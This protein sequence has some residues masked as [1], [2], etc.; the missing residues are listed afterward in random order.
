MPRVPHQAGRSR[1]DAA[2]ALLRRCGLDPLA[3]AFLDP[4]RGA[5]P[6]P[7]RDVQF[8]LEGFHQHGLSL[9]THSSVTPRAGRRIGAGWRPVRSLARHLQ[10]LQQA[11]A[12][13][14]ATQRRGDAAS[15]AAVALLDDFPLV[16]AQFGEVR[17]GLPA[18][19]GRQLPRLADGPQA[20]L[21][22]VH[23][24]ARAFVAHTDSSFDPQLLA[25]F[26]RAYQSVQPLTLRELRTLPTALRAVLLE[27][28]AHL[29]EHVTTA[30]AARDL[31]HAC[32]DH[33]DDLAEAELEALLPR[34]RARGALTPFLA[35]MGQRLHNPAQPTPS[36]WLAWL[37]AHAP[38]AGAELAAA[39]S[40]AAANDVSVTHALQALRA[41]A[42]FDWPRF[43]EEA[44]PLLQVLRRSKAF[45]ADSALTQDQCTQQIERWA[46]RLKGDELA[47][48]ERA[49]AL[50]QAPDAPPP[51][52]VA[53]P[54]Y[55]LIGPGRAE[56]AQ[57][58]GH[59]E[60]AW[61]MPLR[62]R[63][64]LYFGTAVLG[65]LLLVQALL[66]DHNLAPWAELLSLV[67]LA[68]P[69][70]ECAFALL[71]RLI[72]EA[73]PPSRLPRLALERGL[74]PQH[75]TLVVVPC[76]LSS[77]RE[78]VTLAAQLEQ[79][80]LANP[81]RETQFALLSDWA[82]APHTQ[83][84]GD[85]LLLD[86]ARDAIASLNDRHPGP[87]G[88]A[89]R[90]LLL[91]RPRVW[92]KSEGA[93]LGWERTRGK[94]EQLL[95]YLAGRSAFPFVDLGE[96]SRLAR[97]IVY[98]L[99]LDPG[100]VVPP[101]ALRELIAIAAHPLNAPA[102]DAASGRVTAGHAV[103]Q[104]RVV[105][106][107][108]DGGGRP[109][110]V[111]RWLVGAGEWGTELP[112]GHRTEVYQDVFGEGSYA[113]TGLLDVRAAQA[114]LAGRVPESALLSHALYEGL[115]TRCAQVDDVPVLQPQ[116]MQPD[117]AA[118]RRHR[119]TRGAWQLLPFLWPALHG[120]V[121]AANL[122]KMVDPLR[123]S[124]LAPVCVL[125]LCWACATGAVPPAAAVALVLGALGLAPLSGALAA[126]VPRRR[127][128]AWRHFLRDAAT[129]LRRAALLTL[130]QFATLLDTAVREIDAIARTLWR[131]YGSR[132]R[133]LDW[134]TPEQPPTAVDPELPALARQHRL[135]LGVAFVGVLLALL[136][137]GHSTAW[138]L[139]LGALWLATPAWTWLA[140]QPVQRRSNRL[141]TEQ[142]RSL[143]HLARDTWSIFERLITEQDHHL[144]PEHLQCGPEPTVAHR[145]SPTHIGLYLLASCCAHRFGFIGTDE[146]IDRLDATL[147]S[148][149]R[150]PKHRGH[151]FHRID[152]VSLSPLAPRC[153]STADSGH[154]AA[155]L[156]AAAAACRCL[157]EGPQPQE[158]MAEALVRAVDRLKHASG[159]SLPAVLGLPA[160]KA[161]LEEDLWTLWR[162]APARLRALQQ[163]A[164]RAWLDAPPEDRESPACEPVGALLRQLQSLLRDREVDRDRWPATLRALAE[165]ADAL[166]DAMD[167]RF[168]YD[169]RR[170]LLHTGYDVDRQALSANHHTLLA[171]EARLASFVAIAKGE[172]P[173]SHW[174]ELGRPFIG[175]DDMPT[176]RSGSGSMLEY[177]MPRLVMHE[178]AG[179]LLDRVAQG[180][181]WA[182]RR[183]GAC[184]G[185]PW[186]LS[187]AA[188]FA[189][190]HT[191][192]FQHAVFGVP[193]LAARR[194]PPDEEVIAPHASVL[195]AQVDP[196]AAS[197][198]LQRL[199]REGARDR[200]GFLDA[201]DFTPSRLAEDGR[202]RRV[203]TFMTHHQAM[204][205]VALANVLHD[206][207]A[208]RWFAQSV[209]VR[210]H[211]SLLQE[212][213][214]RELVFQPSADLARTVRP[215][216]DAPVPLRQLDL[217]LRRGVPPTHLLGNGRY[218]VALRP[219]GAG[220]S[221]W[222]GRAIHRTEDDALRDA[223]GTWLLLRREGDT[224]FHSLT[225][226][227]SPHPEAR[228]RTR[229]LP[230]RVE[231]D[232]TTPSW[233]STTTVWVS[234]DDDIEFRSVE[235]HNAS[236]EAVEFE[237]LSCFE[238]V[239]APAAEHEAH[240]AGSKL[241]VR[242]HPADEGCLVLER[243]PRHPEEAAMWAAHFVAL[244]DDEPH[245]VRLIA[246]RS[247][248]VPRLGAAGEFRPGRT[249]LPRTD[250]EIPTGLDP[251][252]AIALRLTLPP[253]ARRH[254]TFATT[255]ADDL[256]TIAATV[257][258]Y[259]HEVHL[260]RSRLMAATL[261]RLRQRE[262][263]LGGQDLA[264]LQD[265]T[266]LMQLHHGRHRP[267]A[268]APLDRR[269]LW[270]FG[271]SGDKPLLLLRISGA[272]AL[273]TM[274]LLLAA[275]RLWQLA[276]LETDLVLLHQE[277][278]S[279]H[280]PLAYQVQAARAA[281]G[282][283]A[284]TGG[285]H[286]LR[287]NEVA[288]IELATLQAL[289]RVELLAD[290]QPIVRLLEPWLRAARHETT[291]PVVAVDTSASHRPAPIAQGPAPNE[292]ASGRF[293]ADGR[294][295]EILI[296]G[297][298]ITPRPWAN[299]LANPHFGCVITEAGGGFTWA[300]DSRLN[301]LTPRRCDP[302]LDPPGEQFL[303]C[304][305]DGR[306][307]FPLMPTLDRRGGE[308]WCVT[309][310]PGFTHFEQQRDSLGIETT[311]AVHPELAAKV[312]RVRL[313]NH[314]TQPRRLRLLGLVEWALGP[315]R[316]DR[317]TLLTEAATVDGLVMAQQRER[318]HGFGGGTAWLM[319][320]GAAVEQWSCAREEFF[321]GLGR[322]QWPELLSGRCGSGLDPC[323]AIASRVEIGAAASVEFTWLL[324]WAES[325]DAALGLARQLRQTAV[326]E[327]PE[328]AATRWAR[329][330]EAV[331][332]HTP[333][334]WFDALVNHWL[335]YQTLAC[336]L[337]SRAGFYE[338]HG[339]V[340]FREQLQQAM[341]LVYHDAAALRAQIVLH[342]GRQ[343]MEGDVQHHWHPASGAGPRTRVSD[344]ALWLPY[345]LQHYLEVTGD[346]SVLDEPVAFIDSPPVPPGEVHL[347]DVPTPSTD[348]AS[349]YEHAAR[350]LDHALRLGAHDLPLMGSGDV[351][352]GLDRVGHE[353][354]GE[355]VW[356][357]WLLLVLL[358]QWVPLAQRRGD[359]ERADRWPSLRQRLE[360]A[361]AQ[362]GWDG[363]WW[364]RAY[365]DSGEPLGSHQ[366]DACEIDLLPQAWSVFGSPVGD[367]RARQAMAAADARLVDR[368]AGLLRLLDPP[369]QR[370]AE[371]TG[372]I[373]AY[374]AGVRENGGQ[375]AQ[376]GV[377]ALMA[378]A[379]LGRPD[380][381]WE[382]FTLLSPAHRC[383]TPAGLRRYRLEPY[384]AAGD[385]CSQAPYEGQ[386]GRSWTTSAS[387]WLYRAAIETL[388]GLVLRGG[389]VCFAP[390]L[391]PH[392]PEARISL[393]LR[394]KRIHVLLK[395][396]Q[397]DRAE[398]PL[399]GARVVAAGQ[400]LDLS[401]LQ[402]E[403]HLLLRVPR[404]PRQSEPYAPAVVEA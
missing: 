21:P 104:P 200:Y 149:E 370:Q 23:G 112:E 314:R 321:D 18:R 397:G 226:A 172:A 130:W 329:R 34:L 320:V 305:A 360:A 346:T 313:H 49:L 282:V 105:A 143:H 181:V 68:W 390:S 366:N 189:H 235:L 22:R 394:G 137:A 353:G 284:G 199:E 246:D 340:G 29:A 326:A 147:R 84:P 152:T 122:W 155:H 363:Q 331:T 91:H 220:S 116:P 295:F 120:R 46:Q 278:L 274:Q 5:L 392:W 58:L 37:R 135:T 121:G 92:S 264:P 323:G 103:Y 209:R 73:L 317:M 203:T 306:D 77:S 237:L 175:V 93:W 76:V 374:P 255:A 334:P 197:D 401:G 139:A 185:R 154:L 221:T 53:G 342:A 127:G 272:P 182:H 345:A 47:I 186:G 210:A 367:A 296:D 293:S 243:R 398:A 140:L 187:E 297:V 67:L 241:F 229:L 219:S 90:F 188:Y 258:K 283:P 352:E 217:P 365:F 343:F 174:A 318:S 177:L 254:L 79:H 308:G 303:A 166:A 42:A 240:P 88:T 134:S 163:A 153:V 194:M 375:N 129:E 289:A 277:I 307:P 156:W 234:A 95:G 215:A 322:L 131:V 231:F 369:L 286:V 216:H 25:A 388:L 124:L 328:Q 40:S 16:A 253:G 8:G 344:D 167:F 31:A 270:R 259:R 387:G 316:T 232:A 1:W 350:A 212:R 205:L 11:H 333:D 327:V 271:I 338:V 110:T 151:L 107:M 101:G 41:I 268:S 173:T 45:A 71:N 119:E 336:G 190:D 275:H 395:V 183:Y 64:P 117:A 222:C 99:T 36:R 33:A 385:I 349:V 302:L 403:E 56:L 14:E 378:Q 191:L 404:S 20:G 238:A 294:A 115:W 170:R 125:L 379:Q 52:R 75:R 83:M 80:H 288:P 263:S 109:P 208:Q 207:L 54:G 136:Q 242:A 72:A 145:S 364:R 380:L 148:V 312:L 133:L 118:A 180:A 196:R 247:R 391:P 28:L 341:A 269:A 257:D 354:R 7:V 3:L 32:C 324:G 244:S 400:W 81:E 159:P 218:A 279:A 301:P 337:W 184:T 108:P 106:P 160:I 300:G 233:H 61:R 325:R 13:L 128:I 339:A 381:A 85:R 396:A 299:V 202:P 315:T 198:N 376:A 178:P 161:L 142:R 26:L 2:D 123:R 266:T 30:K 169:P 206:G 35:Q 358:E 114:A 373:A 252:A 224:D 276:G 9:P 382:Y 19:R 179:S 356:L 100:T 132:R 214:P 38:D 347:H 97:D 192:S 24:I 138:T 335:P 359:R 70:S 89:P 383:Q 171:S 287:A 371:R 98:L 211:A 94:I 63:W 15:P 157:A 285:V 65:T 267:A 176:L 27:N 332:V 17:N 69:A 144:P 225:H 265:L 368:R 260:Q 361:L 12:L 150:L 96:E 256:P 291:G 195:A 74:E 250:G 43:V 158:A 111:F 310:S 281:L 372:C 251:V 245:A 248:L 162:R 239:L 87:A 213:L 78:I 126:F 165:R 82:D 204:S 146:L 311:V 113:G 39:Q 48:A 393:T 164:S 262:L 223:Q 290:G 227:P 399:P 319:L 386:G 351:N 55:Y 355:S 384:V 86:A 280:A 6:A 357:A 193:A 236:V 292:V 10:T 102:A 4:A 168:L 261:A 249:P 309:H 402:D 59:A 57:Q 50:A 273:P 44:S 330:L 60:L 228:Y 66:G 230:D 377:W 62:W 51:A 298:R 389:R 304:E 362:H 348:T 201:L 141:D